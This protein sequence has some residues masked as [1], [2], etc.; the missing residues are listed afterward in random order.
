MILS[1]ARLGITQEQDIFAFD[2]VDFSPGVHDPAVVGGDYGND[3]DAFGFELG[4]LLDVGGQVEGLAAGCEGSGDGDDD[5]FLARPFFGG[6]VFLGLLLW[7]W[8][9]DGWNQSHR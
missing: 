2:M 1:K 9:L 3:I 4:E 8:W 6:V 5:Y 7:W